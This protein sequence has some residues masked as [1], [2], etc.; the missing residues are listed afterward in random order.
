[1]SVSLADVVR[2][3]G[4]GSVDEP[5][6]AA[7][8]ATAVADLAAYLEHLEHTDEA[9]TVTGIT[10]AY[11]DQAAAWTWTDGRPAEAVRLVPV[12]ILDR[13]TC[14]VAA[15]LYD[16]RKAPNG[17]V[18]TQ[19]VGGDAAGSGPARLNRDPMT[20]AYALLARWAVPF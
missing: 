14:Q 12:E 18:N 5:D 6:L 3:V 7:D 16:R 20:A 15:D 2:F 10:A 1:M 13:A 4:A 17:I 8:L 11:D 9:G 19:F